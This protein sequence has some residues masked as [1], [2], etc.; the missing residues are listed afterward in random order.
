MKCDIQQFVNAA[1]AE[2]AS[3]LEG[4][5]AAMP[6]RAR[7]SREHHGFGDSGF[8]FKSKEYADPAERGLQQRG[9]AQC[10][11]ARD[12]HLHLLR[13]PDLHRSRHGANRCGPREGHQ[14]VLVTALS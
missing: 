4:L 8:P 13:L 2:G 11:L 14:G 10:P 3:V 1:A 12:P 9:C 7:V 6:H 5:L